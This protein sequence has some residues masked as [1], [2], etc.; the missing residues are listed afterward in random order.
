[1]EVLEVIASVPS[2]R[3]KEKE[4]EDN[5][6]FI[7]KKNSDGRI[8]GKTVFQKGGKKKGRLTKGLAISG[9]KK[10]KR[11]ISERCIRKKRRR[12]PLSF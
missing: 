2:M 5:K 9:G 3:E 6:S 11:R 4:K 7:S 1:M 8:A 12:S 10:G